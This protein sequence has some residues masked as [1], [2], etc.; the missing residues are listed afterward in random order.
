MHGIDNWHKCYNG[1]WKGLIVP[2]AFGHPAKVAYGLAERIYQHAIK[3]G[4][5][6]EGSVVADPFGGIGGFALHAKAW[7]DV[8]RRGGIGGEVCKTW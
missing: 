2:E 8:V 4:W 5:L 7:R 3:E 6:T 1:G